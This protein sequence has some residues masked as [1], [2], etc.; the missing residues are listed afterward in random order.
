MGRPLPVDD[1][2][3]AGDPGPWFFGELTYVLTGHDCVASAVIGWLAGAFAVGIVI[4]PDAENGPKD[5]P[6]PRL[7]QH[8]LLPRLKT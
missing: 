8:H 6:E 5:D 4:E 2:P 3:D 1:P 7:G